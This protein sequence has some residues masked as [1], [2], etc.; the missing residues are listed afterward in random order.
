MQ[1]SSIPLSNIERIEILRGTGAVL[2]GDGA[3]MGVINIVSR[4]PLKRGRA[5]EL[6]ARAASYSTYEAQL[7]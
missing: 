1:W 6:S 3:T 4:S 2:Q 5:F 7:S